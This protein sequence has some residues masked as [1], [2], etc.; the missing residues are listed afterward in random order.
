M[1]QD[2]SAKGKTLVRKDIA[3]AV[4]YLSAMSREEAAEIVNRVFDL[5]VET[6]ISGEEV[7]LHGFGKFVIREKNE[8]IGRNPKTGEAAT[9]TARRVVRFR[10]SVNLL[11]RINKG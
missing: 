2:E 3:E 4:Y 10:P 7:K 5:I 1:K 8:R 9:I 11:E 6:V